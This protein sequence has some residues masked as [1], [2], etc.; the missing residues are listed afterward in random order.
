MSEGEAMAAA[1]QQSLDSY[2]RETLGQRANG[3]SGTHLQN[4]HAHAS[5]GKALP[6]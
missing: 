2:K 3:D 6:N 4:G 5:P 1:K